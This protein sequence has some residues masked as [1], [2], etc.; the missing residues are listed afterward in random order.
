MWFG[1]DGANKPTIKRFLSEF[2]G[3]RV[4]ATTVW[5]YQEVGENRIAAQELNKL[6]GGL[7]FATPKPEALIHRILQVATDPGDL[8][9]DSF[10]GSGT[11]AAVAHKFGRNY[12]GIEI[13]EHAQTHCIPRLIEVVKG[14]QGGVSVVV[15]WAGGGCFRF[16]TLGEPVFDA[17]GSI[18]SKVPFGA[19]A[20][21]LWHFEGPSSFRV[22]RDIHNDRW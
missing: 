8:V 11:T 18:N 2:H 22:E 12:I 19:L 10:L 17:D 13:G 4:V 16:Y 15:N 3:P 5:R 9:L 7:D 14:E 1:K 21:Y 20:S 6:A